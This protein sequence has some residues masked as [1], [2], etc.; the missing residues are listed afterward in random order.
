M[1]YARYRRGSRPSHVTVRGGT[2]G[3]IAVLAPP[4]ELPINRKWTSRYA[5]RKVIPDSESLR[6]GE[7]N[8]P[9]SNTHRRRPYGN[10]GDRPL[11][12]RYVRYGI[13]AGV[14]VCTWRLAETNRAGAS[15]HTHKILLRARLYFYPGGVIWRIYTISGRWRCSVCSPLYD[16]YTGHRHTHIDRISCVIYATSASC[17]WA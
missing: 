6:R 10:L 4:V 15:E 2:L 14:G 8:A 1:P 17:R 16:M 13:T 12:G 3:K 7:H 11:G 9:I 5:K